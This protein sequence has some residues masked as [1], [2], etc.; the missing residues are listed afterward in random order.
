MSAL[1]TRADAGIKGP[2]FLV[3]DHFWAEHG[4]GEA[5]EFFLGMGCIA[6]MPR[7]QGLR[8]IGHQGYL[9]REM[10]WVSDE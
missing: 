8:A 1:K 2:Q 5:E 4:N 3:N 10:E 6:C 9:G 7:W